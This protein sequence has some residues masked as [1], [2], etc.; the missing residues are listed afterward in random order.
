[1]KARN[2]GYCRKPRAFSRE[3]C[4]SRVEKFNQLR[5]RTVQRLT[6]DI[7]GP[8]SAHLIQQAVADAEAL[9][10]STSYP[11]L[12]LPGL[13][14]EKVAGARLWADRQRGVLERQKALAA[15]LKVS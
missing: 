6:A 13:A 2:L 14:E 15:V 11:M 1:M 9:A 10:W 12:F 8:G 3:A 4:K 7:Q 5:E